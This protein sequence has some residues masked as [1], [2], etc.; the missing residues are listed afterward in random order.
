MVQNEAQMVQNEAQ[1][2]QNE[3]QILKKETRLHFQNYV[4]LLTKN[5]CYTLHLK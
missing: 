3:A 1:M 4:F 2:V 5:R